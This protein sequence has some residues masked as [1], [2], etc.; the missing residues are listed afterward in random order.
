[1]VKVEGLISALYHNKVNFVII[2]GQ[3]AVYQ[4]SVYVTADIDICYAREKE[5]LENIV[6]ALKPFHP[7]LRGAEKGLPF[8]FDS[9]TLKKGLNFT[10]AT[11]IGDIDIL[12]EVAGLGSYADIL[13]YSEILEIYNIS[14]KVLTLE[15]L[16]K[17][18]KA[19]RRPKDLMHLKELEAILEIRKQNKS[20]H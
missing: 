17:T 20:K 7:Y 1:M 8:I 18:K 14:C 13:K 9:L 12:G 15:G 11:D 10:F 16:I 2:G 4:G 3:A 19:S 5:N 6:K